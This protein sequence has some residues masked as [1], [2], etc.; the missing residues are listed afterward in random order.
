MV[1]GLT[2]FWDLYKKNRL[3]LLGAIVIAAMLL[4]AVLAPFIS[5]YDP[6]EQSSK[7]LKPPSPR[8]I[9]GTDALGRDVLSQI[10]WGMRLS[11][12][13]AFGVGGLSLLLGIILG[14]IPG[15]Y[16]GMIDDL[17]SRF[18]E[19][20]LMIPPMFIII[21]VVA[22]FG[23]NMMLA[24]LIVG[25]TIWPS[26]ARIIRAQVLTIKTREYVKSAIGAGA[27]DFRIITR[28]V[29]PN[30]IYPVIV[31]STMQMARAIITEASLSFLGLGDPNQP[32]LGQILTQAQLYLNYAWWLAVPAG[33]TISVLVFALTLVGDG[34][35][36]A[37]NPRMR[38]R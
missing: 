31:N 22:L 36:F 26:N 23:N 8:N 25:M 4:V 3:A 17:F 15:Y 21:L 11:L 2:E 38:E 6:F 32:S 29:L 9:L 35:N 27:S 34:I 24:M 16:G 13:F 37:L 1:S 7:L 12:T 10:I 30:G 5:P 18:Y 33:L 14:A 28:H 19:V 20:F